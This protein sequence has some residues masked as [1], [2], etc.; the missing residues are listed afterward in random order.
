MAITLNDPRPASQLLPSIPVDGPQTP[1][2]GIGGPVVPHHE[3]PKDLSSSL[4]D[5]PTE[6][7]GF[8]PEQGKGR[9]ITLDK[10]SLH[11]LGDVT[12]STKQGLANNEYSHHDILQ[13][14]LG[15]E[16][17]TTT[18]RP[19]KP[20]HKWMKTL[21][22]RSVRRQGLPWWDT[23]DTP[24]SMQLD[25]SES[26]TGLSFH[27]RN[28]S[29]GSSF[30]FVTAVKSASISLTTASVLSRS[31]SRRHTLRSSRGHSKADRS[32]RASVTAARF[33]EDSHCSERPTLVD[34][35]VM[36]RSLQ[37]RRI[38][39]ELISTEESYIRD[40]RFLINVYVTILASLPTLPPGLRSSIN[41]NLTE[42]VELHEEM[43]GELHRAVPYSEYTQPELQ[44]NGA[45]PGTRGH[46]RMRSLDAVPEDRDGVSWLPDVTGLLA[47]PQIAAEVAKIF[48]RKM[49]RFF[50][51]EEYG[52]K[53]ELM[54]KDVA[55]AHRTMPGWQSYQK[56]LEVLASSLGSANSQL[57]HGKKSLSIGDLL[58]KPIQRVCKYPLLFAELLKYTPVVDCPCSHMEIENALIRL[59]EATAEINRATDDMR[60]KSV[61]EKTWMLQDRLVFANHQLD[62]VSKNRI[63]SFGH[64]QLCGALHACWQTKDGVGGEYM[65]ALLYREWFCLATA[66]RFDQI[67][68]IQACIAL[69]NVKVEEVDNG[70]G[71]QCHTAPYSWK[72]VFICDHQLYE[73]ILTACTPKE[74]LEW[75]T[76]LSSHQAVES[77]DQ[78]QSTLFSSLSL[79]IK[80]LGTVFRKPGT[81]ARRISIH[82]ATTVG[83]KSPLCQ[84][85]LKNT[86]VMKDAP[87]SG[88]AR[89]S[90]INRSQSL[91]T[92]NTRIPVLAPSRGDRAR[93][94][95]LLSDVWTRDILP[96]PGITARSRSEH[97][98]RT[99][100][101]SVIRK[102][103]VVSITSSFTRR[104]GRSSASPVEEDAGFFGTSP[105]TKASVL[106]TP[107]T[108]A[109][110]TSSRR[111]SIDQ[112]GGA[113]YRSSSLLSVI[114]DEAD[115]ESGTS[116]SSMGGTG[117][118]R[119]ATTLDWNSGD[120]DRGTEEVALGMVRHTG[121]GRA[122]RSASGN[123]QL[124]ALGDNTNLAKAAKY[125]TPVATSRRSSANTTTSNNSSM[126]SEAGSRPST[127][128]SDGIHY[129]IM[130]ASFSNLSV[131][132]STKEDE[133]QRQATVGTPNTLHGGDDS[134]GRT[135]AAVAKENIC[136][137]AAGP[138]CLPHS[139]SDYN[140]RP[141][142]YSTGHKLSRSWT[143]RRGPGGHREAVVQSIKNMF[144]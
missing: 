109:T 97:L 43:L 108:P 129:G 56:G 48:S 17:T 30:G 130:S 140:S 65:V 47:D 8:Q 2:E 42:I 3:R 137:D 114:H 26:R 79:N 102:L 144:R 59:R 117:V 52:A 124:K 15:Y 120:G 51:Y 80:S 122:V 143:S 21:H 119:K 106:E 92:T 132:D 75:R 49:N 28:S 96:F 25:G 29:S 23:E 32:S 138:P 36:E 82:R 27:R 6:T 7:T 41:R 90:Q 20:F 94:E 127:I 105:P 12:S 53:Y 98:V 13:R 57:D 5:P 136:S 113:S 63:R 88:G 54:I 87:S 76:R 39:E 89:S 16:S 139:Y 71:L 128:A 37:R 61:L 83:P 31:R 78:P 85:I 70:R 112:N 116:P 72:M 101:S 4:V 1:S 103:S 133:A 14:G 60:V 11:V 67:Y 44:S 131:Q 126:G 18:A 107:L 115:R 142:R 34:P 91:L 104:S 58:V 73:V 134:S 95:A 46:Q 81:I 38:L 22:K 35:V 84:V 19:S 69:D 62:A 99:S 100:A 45:H 86:S 33:S 24:Y 55:A 135:T 40:V 118:K 64:V 121:N 74:E 68:T 50:V 125:S 110:A 123:S 93:I 111:N 10:I 66:G 77:L 141:R 9:G